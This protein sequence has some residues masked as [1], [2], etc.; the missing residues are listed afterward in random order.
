[1]GDTTNTQGQTFDLNA[2]PAEELAQEI[3]QDPSDLHVDPD[4]P[5][6]VTLEAAVRQWRVAKSL[7]HLRAQINAAFPHRSKES[8]GTIG[9]ARHASRSSDHNPW[10]VDNGMGVVTAFDVTHDP[11]NGCD[12]G[13]IAEAIRA[14]DDRRVKYI[15]WNRRIANS[16]PIGAA[17]AWAWRAY[18]GRNPH[19][20]H[21][22][23]SVRSEKAAYDVP[24][25]WSFRTQGGPE[26]VAA[27]TDS[28]AAQTALGAAL[29]ALPGNADRPL[30]QRLVDAQ[31][32]ISALLAEYAREA[33]PILAEDAGAEEA[34]RPSF[35][36]LQVEYEQLW[37]R[38]EIRPERANSV[39]WHR[40]KLLQNKARYEQVS[41]A[42]GAKWWFIGI[43]HALEAS[44]NFQGHL[45]NGDP[46]GRRTVNVPANRPPRWNP[47]NDWLSSAIDA[48]TFEGFAGQSDWS[49][50][51]TLYRFESYNGFGYHAKGINSPYLWSFS[52]H[53]TRGKFIRDHVYDPNAVSAQCGSA[54]ML[55]SLQ[56][57]GEALS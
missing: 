49:L 36:Q 29:D 2:R 5:P 15:I 9:D 16:Q 11:R 53:Y 46:L 43:V 52:T 19:N 45:H 34:T 20:H 7:E 32:E 41:A 51:R 4:A 10:V 55:K 12:A 22:H 23:I 28:E 54:V 3:V 40:A 35:E 48:I 21:C 1:M 25:D 42:T 39:A 6:E 38:C 30:L 14:S 27:A 13:R 17:K 33:R 56:M 24:R 8:D 47:P 18:T 31:D 57:A 26:A 50:A 44:F 37:E